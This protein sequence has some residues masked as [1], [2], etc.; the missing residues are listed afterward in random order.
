VILEPIPDDW[1]W[2]DPLVGKLDDDVV[3]AVNE[4]VPQQARPEL[5]KLFP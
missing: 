3:E 4:P 1:V 5:D 2:R